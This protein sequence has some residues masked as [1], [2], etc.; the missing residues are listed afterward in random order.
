MM[1]FSVV[2]ATAILAQRPSDAQR[3]ADA[4]ARIAR[5]KNGMIATVHPLATQAAVDML[6]QGGNAI[7]AAIMAGLMLG[8]VDGHNSGIGG[9]CFILIHTADG[10]T[11]AIDGRET[12]PAAAHRKLFHR[13]GKPLTELSQ[14]GPLAAGVPGALAAYELALRKYGRLPMRTMLAKSADVAE[15]GFSL[16]A[17]DVSRINSVKRVFGKYPAAAAIFLNADGNS[18]P[19]GTLLKQPDLARTYR[20]IAEGGIDWFYRG[21]FAA[22]T[23]EWMGQNGGIMTEQDFADYRAIERQPL[24]TSYRDCTILGFP[25]PSSGGVHIAQMLKMLESFDLGKMHRD[26]PANWYHHVAEAMKLAFADRAFWLGDPAF[27]KVPKGLIADSYARQL[28]LRIV[29]DKA[30]SV[31]RHSVPEDAAENVFEKHTTHISTA[32]AAGNWVA[33]T[34]TVNTTYG[35]KVVVPG[36]GVVLNN[37]MDDFA[38]APGVANAFG[39]L[40]SEANEVAPGKRPL[41]SMSPTIVLREGKPILSVGAAGGPRIISQTLMM[42]LR[43][44][45]LE[46]SV[47]DAIV[48]PRIHHQWRPD[49]L[50]V[51]E[52]LSPEI[53]DELIRRGHILQA[54]AGIAVVQGVERDSSSFVGAHDPKVPG[55]AAGL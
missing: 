20:A 32:D 41:S 48:A 46:M 36:L 53:R 50:V 45:D 24:R 19:A 47:A 10:Q 15:S 4:H 29:P 22:Q 11:I 5:A 37:E 6:A 51:S 30:I 18:Y 33:M 23:A 17:Q 16:T 28:A 35:C 38:I 49:Q 39:L 1:V 7:D 42:L 8:V 34:Q 43:K 13:D 54:N 25:P 14:D 52:P 40:G 3:P 27:A 26:D 12:A 44:I 55:L 9:G 21:L 31:P 2:F